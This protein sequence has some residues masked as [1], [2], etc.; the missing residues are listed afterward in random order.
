M[1]SASVADVAPPRVAPASA[2][3]DVIVDRTHCGRHVTG[4]E[5]ITLELFSDEAL[6]PLDALGV[7]AGSR[8]QMMARQ[9]FLLPW[10]AARRPGALIICPGFPPTPALTLLGGRVLPYIHDMF[11]ITR[12]QD[13]NIR[14]RLYM[15][16]PF[17]LA[18][19]RLPRFLV[20]SE[21]TRDELARFCR[22]DAEITLYRPKVRNVFGLAPRG[23]A[24]R[25]DASEGLRLVALGT[26]E[27][28]KNL[29]AAARIVAAL[30]A[31]GLAGT[32]LDVVGRVGWGE[33]AALLARMPGV[34]LHGYQPVEAVRAMVDAA[35]ALISTS[36]DEGL[37]LPLI[38]AQY[39]GLPVI[40]PDKRVF[41]E[42]LGTSGLFIAPDD[43]GAAAGAIVGAVS[44]EGWRARAQA[45]A[46]A[47]LARWNEN[48][49]R[50]RAGVIE[51][52][53]RL[54]AARGARAC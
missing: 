4:L 50:D 25:G 26:V 20:N 21:Y 23:R 18:V 14:A 3:P 38:E 34:T 6:A 36:H 31:R 48:A 17:R 52:I 41:R 46:L 32:R 15:A 49:E 16:R 40:A 53:G 29:M 12:A 44:G 8:L 10:L 33:D 22:P 1:T 43:A 28:R 2:A 39:A 5:R 42:A 54:A 35:D 13:L 9:T 24:T 19:T 51:L 30:R 7:T 45:D 11:L 47:N 27:P 37:G